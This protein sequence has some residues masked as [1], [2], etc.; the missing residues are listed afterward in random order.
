MKKIIVILII[1]ACYQNVRC[2]NND[3]IINITY[4][5]K[6]KLDTVNLKVN[7][8]MTMDYIDIYKYS[9]VHRDSVTKAF[10]DTLNR[11]VND[12]SNTFINQITQ[13]NNFKLACKYP[14][15]VK[16]I[17]ELIDDPSKKE[18]AFKIYQDSKMG[19][20]VNTNSEINNNTGEEGVEGSAKTTIQI[21]T[22][23]SLIQIKK[24]DIRIEPIR[25]KFNTQ[26]IYS[27][28]LIIKIE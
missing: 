4:N 23:F 20:L 26:N 19:Q 5:V 14:Q 17:I 16:N 28:P 6:K 22:S 18:K 11:F 8:K 24:S 9:P 25:F 1:I 2:Q 3:L 13:N 15:Y 21:E 7:L 12:V 10:N 27:E